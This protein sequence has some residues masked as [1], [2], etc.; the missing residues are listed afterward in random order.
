MKFISQW[1]CIYAHMFRHIYLCLSLIHVQV[2]LP[3]PMNVDRR[4]YTSSAN[5]T[6]RL[7]HCVRLCGQM[8]GWNRID[9]NEEIQL[10]SL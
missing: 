1:F 3:E 7:A 5:L 2:K 6:T 9:T 4:V 8:I 10:L